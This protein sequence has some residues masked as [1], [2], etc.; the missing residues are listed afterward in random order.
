MIFLGLRKTEG[1][2]TR[3]IPDKEQ[4]LKSKAVDAMMHQGL[5][6]ISDHHLRLTV[7]GLVM[8]TEVMVQILGE[9]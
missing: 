4:L 2:D 5:I 1:I 7:K 3:R 8:S 9:T 6:E